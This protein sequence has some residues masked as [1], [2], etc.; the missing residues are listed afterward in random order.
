MWQRPQE[1]VAHERARKP[2]EEKESYR[3]LEGYQLACEVQQ[4]CPASLVVNVAD[5]EGDSQECLLEAMSREGADRAELIIGAKCNRRLATGHDQG[6]LWPEMPNTRPLGSLTV[7]VAR[8]RDRAPRQATLT[9][10]TRRVTFTGARRCGGRLPPVEVTVIDAKE[11]RPP[12]GEEAVEWRLLTSLAV[13]DF[14]S[15][16]TIVQWYRCRWE[17]EL[18]VRVLQQGCQ[19]E[20]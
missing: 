5:R 18:F 15:A 8:Q 4:R 7:E 10:A 13:E 1:P 9:V 11:S 12:K 20:Q 17:I 2:I 19:I 14:P 3:W 16:C 6:Y